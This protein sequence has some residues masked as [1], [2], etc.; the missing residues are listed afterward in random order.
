MRRAPRPAGAYL[1]SRI[2]LG[3][4]FGLETMRAL[5]AALGHPERTFTTLLVAGTN[6]K[7]SVV[8]YVDSVLRASG[9]FSAKEQADGSPGPMYARFRKRITF[10][11]AN[12]AGKVIAFTARALDPD[13]KTPNAPDNTMPSTA[14]ATS[15]S[16][17]VKPRFLTTRPAPRR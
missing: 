1:S 11:I 3:M 4:K 5:A 12:E 13:E 8:A 2:H 9:L 14:S 15:A 16:S 10:P 7:G 17:S 6:G